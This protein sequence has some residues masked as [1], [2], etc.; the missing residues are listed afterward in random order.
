MEFPFPHLVIDKKNNIIL[1]NAHF[2][3][4]FR[5]EKSHAVTNLSTLI[6]LYKNNLLEQKCTVDLVQYK[7]FTTPIADTETFD[8]YMIELDNDKSLVGI[9]FIDNFD[10]VLDSIEE[11]KRP[12]LVALI[13]RKVN[14]MSQ[15]VGGIV[16]KFENDKYVFVFSFKKLEVLKENKFDILDKIRETDLGNSTP[17]TLSIGIGANGETLAQ[18]M[19]YARAALDL[20]LSRG[21]DQ[22]LI[23]DVDKFYFF[24]GKSKDKITNSRVRARVKAYGLVELILDSKNVLV[25]GHHSPDI[26]CLGAAVGIFKIATTLGRPCNIILNTVTFNISSFYNRIILE[27]PYTGHVFINNETAL[28][29]HS[30]KTLV[31]IVDT[32]R[33]QLTECPALVQ[34]SKRLVVFDHHRKS[35]DFIE[36]SV[37]TYHE[38]FASST[39]ELITEMLLYIDKEIKLSATEADGM[40][41]G[42]ALDT[43]NF[44]LKTGTKTFESAAY[45]RRN[46]ADPVRVKM[47]FQNSMESY[48]AKTNTVCNAFVF[49]TIAAISVVPED[50]PYPPLVAAQAA[51]ELLDISD[52][53]AS[54]V[55]CQYEDVVAI[56][57]RS[58]GNVNVQLIMEKLGGGGHQTVSG[59][60]LK[61][62]TVDQTIELLKQ[63]ISD[64]LKETI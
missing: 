60:Q 51:D 8:V 24:G 42:I 35:P 61:D 30:D 41:A 15:Q 47:L 56:C 16:R 44:E 57:A 18:N 46:G 54:F 12:L 20:A 28:L 19:E 32:H 21:G 58:L 50:A 43:K 4:K 29:L 37:L 39:C 14:T 25:M 40:L 55:L 59:C 9:I 48:H 34:K 64:Y 5:T 31:I 11:A 33:P 13:D 36:D 2:D 22:V 10:E 7:L 1:S 26:D 38:P 45:L 62:T 52:I 63:A 17:V 49:E 3:S 6:G 23:K 53:Q 27:K